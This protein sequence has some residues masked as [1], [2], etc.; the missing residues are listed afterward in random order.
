VANLITNASKYSEPGT[1]ISITAER[2][3]GDVRLHVIDEGIGIAP[4]L[5]DPIFDIFFQPAQAPDR[6]KGG[7]GL[8]LTI[9]RSLVELH[10]G[11]VRARSEGPGRGSEFIVTLPLAVPAAELAP[12]PTET[13]LGALASGAAPGGRRILIVDDNDDAAMSIAELLAEL[14]HEVRVAHDGPSALDQARRFRP[15]VCLLDIGLPVMD[16]YELARRLRES[17]ALP[18]GARIIAVTGYGQ[19]ADR[20]RSTE[21]GF[22]AHVVKPVDLEVLTHVVAN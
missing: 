19:D 3:D 21:A 14:G 16:G 10:G 13:G 12:A 22:S 1:K 8:G 18:E 7:L 5:L 17:R 9:V 6:S 4:D 2:A 11:S 20:R 15:E